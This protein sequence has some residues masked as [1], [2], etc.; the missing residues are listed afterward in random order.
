MVRIDMAISANNV[1]PD[2]NNAPFWCFVPFVGRQDIRLW[3]NITSSV[4]Q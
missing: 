4:V 3:Q 2:A 1:S